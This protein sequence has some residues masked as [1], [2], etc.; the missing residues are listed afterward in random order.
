MNKRMSA[1]IQQETPG[2][3]AGFCAMMFGMLRKTLSIS[4]LCLL[5]LLL[6]SCAR[7]TSVSTPV[8]PSPQQLAG[9]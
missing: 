9:N 5:A 8:P 3:A 4:S 7:D 1:M 6:A 2:A